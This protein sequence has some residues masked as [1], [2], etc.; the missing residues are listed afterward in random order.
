MLAAGQSLTRKKEREKRERE[1]ANRYVPFDNVE[2]DAA[3]ARISACRLHSSMEPA[4]FH[5][6]V[7]RYA[8]CTGDQQLL[9]STLLL[10][11]VLLLLVSL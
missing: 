3:Q 9:Y 7:S 4:G 10:S 1:S 8:H 6:G 5:D 11:C 2:S